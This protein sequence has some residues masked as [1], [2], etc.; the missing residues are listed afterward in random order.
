ML[1][2]TRYKSGLDGS[3][4]YHYTYAGRDGPRTIYKL[5]SNMS[6]TTI[7]REVCPKC[8]SIILPGGLGCMCQPAPVNNEPVVIL[9]CGDPSNDIERSNGITYQ[10]CG[11]GRR[12]IRKRIGGN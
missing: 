1:L 11:G 12:I 10:R 5:E 8:D 4:I 2:Q 9:L 7:T 3:G 6:A